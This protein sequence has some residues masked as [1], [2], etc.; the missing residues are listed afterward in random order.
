MAPSIWF[1]PPKSTQ[2]SK[3]PPC[4][5]LVF[6]GPVSLQEE[7]CLERG[8]Q[9]HWII[10]F[11]FVGVSGFIVWGFSYPAGL[12]LGLEDV[13]SQGPCSPPWE[14]HSI[15]NLCILGT[16]APHRLYE[17]LPGHEA[18]LTHVLR[19]L[20]TL[21]FFSLHLCGWATL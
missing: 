4:C 1:L 20:L 6:Q 15:A 13:S 11:V 5:H 3:R 19:A 10:V 18:E 21:C 7:G 16:N 8:T 14:I 17:M 12:A 9:G 2:W